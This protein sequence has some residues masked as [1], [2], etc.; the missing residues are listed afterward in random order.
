MTTRIQ[1]SPLRGHGPRPTGAGRQVDWAIDWTGQSSG[2]I[3]VTRDKT[4][5]NLFRLYLI[6][7]EA[8]DPT[9]QGGANHATVLDNRFHASV[10][11]A[12]DRL[13]K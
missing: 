12:S 7:R 8:P 3:S 6:P 4:Q 9:A 11:K 10:A 5:P 13:E 1:G 2:P